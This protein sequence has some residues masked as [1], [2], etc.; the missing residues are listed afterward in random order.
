V[1][2]SWRQ[3]ISAQQSTGKNDLKKLFHALQLHQ[4]ELEMQNEELRRSQAQLET[5][6]QKKIERRAAEMVKTNEKLRRELKQRKRVEKTLLESEQRYRAVV[7][8]QTE[9]ICRFLPDGRLT[10]VNDAYSR[11]FGKKPAELIGQRFLDQIPQ[12]DL[13]RVKKHLAAIN[14]DNPIATIKHRVI[15]PGGAIRWQQWIDRAIFDDQDRVK[16]YQSVGRDITEQVQAQLSIR[17]REQLLQNVIDSIQDGIS[18]LDKDLNLLRVNPTMEKWYPQSKP[19]KGRKC[20]EVYHGKKK[21]CRVCPSV[22]ALKSGSLQ[23]DI[24]QSRVSSNEEEWFEVF[25]FPILDSAGKPTGVVEYRRSITERVKAEQALRRSEQRFRLLADFTHDWEYWIAPDGNY[26]YVSPSCERITGYHPDE[27]IRDTGLFEKIIHPDDGALIRG[28]FNKDLLCKET[29]SLDFR[30]R[31]R[32]GK[33][34]WIAHICLPVYDDNGQFAGRRASNRDITERKLAQE[35]L[36]EAQK[37]LERRVEERTKELKTSAKKLKTKQKELASH[38][39]KLE[40][41]N[42]D[43]LETNRAVTV[44]ARN[45]DK[46]RRDEE[47][48]FAKTISSKILPLVE[49]LK[50]A[51]TLDNVLL[52]LDFLTV[53]VQDLSNDLTGKMNLLASLTPTELRLASM[54]KKGLPSRRIAD[55]LCVSLHTIKSHRRNIR[56]KLNIQ[57]STINLESYLRSAMW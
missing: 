12:K 5:S 1:E 14:R 45:I 39:A 10:F 48:R 3:G 13:E 17:E 27:F 19:I 51:K 31:T 38:K 49:D 54:I 29:K 9:L 25:A 28:H 24:K 26:I 23:V 50:K 21:P 22:K 30:I 46:H 15:Q 43:L 6:K 57:N 20:H 37:D 53:N 44:L 2:D 56:K 34:R 7:E 11:C 52:G 35:A 33:E 55:K 8:N 32:N 47:S 41:V 36:N 4:F 42:K 16:E 18:V 40:L